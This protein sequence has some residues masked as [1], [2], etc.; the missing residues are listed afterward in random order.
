MVVLVAPE[1]GARSAW[2]RNALLVMV[3]AGEPGAEDAVPGSSL[4]PA[5]R[6]SGALVRVREP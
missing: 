2:M 1:V 4:E 6:T 5:T 3:L